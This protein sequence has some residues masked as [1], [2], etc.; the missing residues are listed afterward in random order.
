L[1]TEKFSVL[2]AGIGG[3]PIMTEARA[4]FWT[5]MAGTGLNAVVNEGHSLFAF[6]AAA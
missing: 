4:D 5:A 6:S 2:H 3:L 1:E